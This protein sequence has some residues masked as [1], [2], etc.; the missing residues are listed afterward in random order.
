M[1]NLNLFILSSICLLSGSPPDWVDNPGGYEFTATIGGGIVNDESGVQMG[2]CETTSGN[3]TYACIDE[4]IYEKFVTL[5][6]E[7]KRHNPELIKRPSLLLLT[8]TDLIPTELLEL[9]KL[10]KEI[11]IVQISSVSGHNLK[12]AI[13]A[14][15]DLIKSQTRDPEISSD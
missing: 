2:E 4:E 5:K 9:E 1:K 13:Q 6:N 14:I 10:S 12:E 7:L 3:P 15:A 8:K 11:P